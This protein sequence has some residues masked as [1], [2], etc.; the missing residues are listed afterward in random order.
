MKN[1]QTR[2]TE[3][4][5]VESDREREP[6]QVHSVPNKRGGVVSFSNFSVPKNNTNTKKKNQ[7]LSDEI[8]IMENNELS[9]DTKEEEIIPSFDY[10]DSLWKRLK[11][12]YYKIEYKEILNLLID[13]I[14]LK[15]Q[16][17]KQINIDINIPLIRKITKNERLIK[18]LIRIQRNIRRF[19]R[20]M[21]NLRDEKSSRI[22][23]KNY[24]NF[25]LEFNR[26]LLRI[27]Q[28]NPLTVWKEYIR[29]IQFRDIMNNVICG[30]TRRFYFKKLLRTNKL[31]KILKN[32]LS[33][34]EKEQWTKYFYL[35]ERRILLT[36][37]TNVYII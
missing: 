23:R 28:P 34:C 19:L 5:E 30:K 35:W 2:I 8:V 11:E 4:E 18:K 29:K 22:L 26:I 36:K 1:K 21:R 14:L 13:F 10:V 7:E 25:F 6:Q 31:Y 3:T 27:L 32:Q 17:R 37:Y 20:R 16:T 24:H 33:I 12:Q 9:L 15:K